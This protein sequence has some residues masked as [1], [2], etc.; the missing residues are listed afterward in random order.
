M[1]YRTLWVVRDR[2]PD[3]RLVSVAVAEADGVADV[4]VTLRRGKVSPVLARSMAL[5]S[6]RFAETGPFDVDL[7]QG[8]RPPNLSVWF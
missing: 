5:F 1:Q 4:T 3:D 7:A 8:A 6:G 2:L